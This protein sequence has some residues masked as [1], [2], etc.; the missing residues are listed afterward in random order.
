MGRS[1][2]LTG[3]LAGC[4][5]AAAVPAAPWPVAAL[6]VAT[7]GGAALLPDIDHPSGTAARSL[8]LL[9]RI[10]ARGVSAACLAAYHATRLE[11]DSGHRR[12]GHRTLSHTVPACVVAGCVVAVSCLV[13]PAAQVGVLALLAGLLAL[14]VREC[15]VSLAL[16][17]GALAWWCA[18]SYPH[19]WWVY[20]AAT[21][22]GC[23]IHLA[24][25]AAT[26]AGVPARWPVSR[27]GR[28][29]ET[30]CWPAT[31]PAGGAVERVL[32]DPALVAGCV[33]AVSWVTGLAPA[34]LAAAT[35]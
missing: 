28:R 35:A 7:T 19:W 4:G 15:G 8:G 12:D 9:T 27:D 6:I 2:A 23:L 32:V 10:L 26:P 24:G 16:A 3:V 1:H 25:D 34:V 29:W 30:V 22:V 17:A 5:L 18:T 11:R 20:G 14:G 31:F 13:A 33:L 21:A